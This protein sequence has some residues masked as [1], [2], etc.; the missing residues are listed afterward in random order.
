M[1]FEIYFDESHKLDRQTSNYSYYG[2]IGWDK[3]IREKFDN[4]IENLNIRNVAS[5]YF[6]ALPIL[7]SK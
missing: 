5:L 2:A 1:S 6:L 4:Y 3:T 7:P